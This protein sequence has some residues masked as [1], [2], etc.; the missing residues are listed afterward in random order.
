MLGSIGA[1]CP[2]GAGSSRRPT[3]R[4]VGFWP[5]AR[6]L[7]ALAA[8]P[9]RLQHAAVELFRGTMVSHSFIAYR[10]DSTDESQPITFAGESWRDYIPI[11]VAMDGVR[12]GTSAPR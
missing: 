2:S 7:Y 9:S 5:I 10:D 8:L 4:N 1:A 6:T 12:S 3:S 11:A